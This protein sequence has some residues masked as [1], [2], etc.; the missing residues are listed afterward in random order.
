MRYI[1]MF[2][3]ADGKVSDNAIMVY[4]YNDE[5]LG[6]FAKSAYLSF[7]LNGNDEKTDDSFISNTNHS[8]ALFLINATTN[9]SAFAFVPNSD[10]IRSFRVYLTGS[11]PV[12]FKLTTEPGNE[13]KTIKNIFQTVSSNGWQTVDFGE[14]I[15][16]TPGQKYYVHITTTSGQVVACGSSMFAGSVA[17]MNWEN[18]VWSQTG[19]VIAAEVFQK[20]ILLKDHTLKKFH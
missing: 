8:I 13:A 2:R 9:N 3:K 19:Y 14:N 4:N 15:L 5:V 12:T 7:R 1:A 20:L 11:A 10:S 18:N 17:S 6:G 16:V